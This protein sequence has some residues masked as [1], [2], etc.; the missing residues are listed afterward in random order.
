MWRAEEGLIRWSA[1]G[2]R[3]VSDDKYGYPRVDM[4]SYARIYSTENNYYIEF[5]SMGGYYKCDNDSSLNY[6]FDGG[7]AIVF[8]LKPETDS[9]VN[10]SVVIEKWPGWRVSVSDQSGN[11]CKLKFTIRGSSGDN[12]EW[13]TTNRVMYTNGFWNYVVI[14]F[15]TSAAIP[16]PEIWINNDK[17][18]V[19][20][21]LTEGGAG[22]ITT[23][24]YVE[25]GSADV[26]IGADSD[27]SN[28]YVGGL[29]EVGL[30]KRKL[31]ETEIETLLTLEEGV[32]VPPDIG[33]IYALVGCVLHLKM[34]DMDDDL[35]ELKD[36]SL[37]END[38]ERVT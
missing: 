14:N 9:F 26:I 2:M 6:I 7:G 31:L 12:I 8:L 13:T 4:E 25:S 30:V 36:L 19:S 10:N 17:Y 33:Q 21:G 24:D 35:S 18:E 11:Y 32:V 29:D 28:E 16:R 20:D 3:V 37:Y 1:A 38:A 27:G 15:N 5:S 23:D 22:D 34:G